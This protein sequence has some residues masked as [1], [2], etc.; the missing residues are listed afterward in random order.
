MR[1]ISGWSSVERNYTGRVVKKQFK[2]I[3]LLFHTY[4]FLKFYLFF[5]NNHLYHVHFQKVVPFHQENFF[6]TLRNGAG[7]F[8]PLS[9][10][11]STTSAASQSFS[12]ATAI[13]NSVLMFMAVRDRLAF[14][15]SSFVEH[16]VQVQIENKLTRKA[17]TN[18]MPFRKNDL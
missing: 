5:P 13:F 11:S 1:V 17:A 2:L 3:E 10:T 9:S 14:I 12:S 8:V 6:A 15:S 4:M 18:D 16:K 7:W